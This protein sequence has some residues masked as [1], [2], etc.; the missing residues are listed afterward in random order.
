MPPPLRELALKEPTTKVLC[1]S[2]TA[3]AE[4]R[5]VDEKKKKKNDGVT[6]LNLQATDLKQMNWI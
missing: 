6:R 2:A 5:D 4:R 1:S 3:G